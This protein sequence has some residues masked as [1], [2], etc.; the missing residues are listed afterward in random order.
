MSY[1]TTGDKYVIPKG[2]IVRCYVCF[3]EFLLGNETIEATPSVTEVDTSALTI[4][5]VARVSGSTVVPVG[6]PL[7]GYPEDRTISNRCGLY[8]TVTSSEPGDYVI[9]AEADTSDHSPAQKLV[10]LC[11]ITIE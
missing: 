9:K 6:S 1:P 10:K 7:Y 5:N 2:S 3:G 4:A 8:F 11:R